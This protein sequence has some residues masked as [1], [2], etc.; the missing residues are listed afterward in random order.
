MFPDQLQWLV[1][2]TRVHQKPMWTL[3]QFQQLA[4]KVDKATCSFNSCHKHPKKLTFCSWSRS[5]KFIRPRFPV[6]A[7]SIAYFPYI[8][9]LF[10][11]KYAFR[12]A[13]NTAIGR[14]ALDV[15]YDTLAV[16]AVAALNCS[17]AIFYTEIMYLG[18]TRIIKR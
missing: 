13:D 4:G 8:L 3:A 14:R 18:D 10:S 6:T 16:M 1:L 9:P 17:W 15:N 5:F 11:L 2:A 12:A 7:L